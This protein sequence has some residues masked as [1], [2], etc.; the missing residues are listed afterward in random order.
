MK[1]YVL[2]TGTG[3]SVLCGTGTML[4]EAG[5][6]S[7]GPQTPPPKVSGARGAC[8]TA[9]STDPRQKQGLA[10]CCG[11]AGERARISP[12]VIAHA[13]ARGYARV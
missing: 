4:D 13:L 5:R 11:L 6:P 9:S 8:E 7:V 3:H 2:G 12:V 10:G 1:M